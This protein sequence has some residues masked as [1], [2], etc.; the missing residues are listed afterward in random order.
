[1]TDTPNT[2]AR[3]RREDC[4]FGLHFDL[5][6]KKTDTSLG[7]DV[8]E[9]NLAELLDRVRPDFVQ[10]DCKGH[11]GYAGYPTKVGWPSPGVVGDSLAVW[12][13]AT[14]E[15]GVALFIHYSGV[16]DGVALE[17]HPEWAALDAD[18][19]PYPGGQV[20]STFGPYVDELLIPQLI[21]AHQAYD[22]DGAWVDGESWGAELDYSPAALAAWKAKTGRDKAPAGPEDDHWL[23][24]KNFHRE[25][26]DTYLCRWIDGVH[27]ACPDAQLCS[28]W[29]YSIAAPLPKRA[30]VDY[31]SGDY[32]PLLSA[33]TG[34]R[35]ARYLAST[36]MPWDLMS[37][38]FIWN[39]DWGRY[40]K[41]AEPVQQEAGAVL[42]QG[43][44]F[45]IYHH[46]TRS[47]HVCDDVIAVAEEVAAFCRVRQ[48]VSHKSTTVP[49]VALLFS[50]ET[51]WDRCQTPF[52]PEPAKLF[53][54]MQGMLHA[55]LELHY[56]VDILA[57][58]QLAPR[59]SEFPLVVIPDAHV[60]APGFREA[61][62]EYVR[63][64]GAVLLAGAKTA[65]LFEDELGVSF[66]G[67]GAQTPACL[68][69]AAGDV[70]HVNGVWQA[71]DAGDAEV[72]SLRTPT[73]DTRAGGEPAATLTACGE[74]QIGAIY[75][76]VSPAYFHTHHPFLREVIGGLTRRLFPAPAV[77]V[78]GPACVDIA[79]RRTADGRLCLHLLNLA[80]AQ[81][82]ETFIATDH[83]PPVGPLKVALQLDRRP[84]AVHWVP[85]GQA[86]DWDWAD[87]VVS[88]TI[89]QVHI[90]GVVV[91]D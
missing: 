48:D 55:L 4:F 87:G 28:N 68:P 64:G 51:L 88:V 9:K 17:H 79:L 18:G 50:T 71:I 21:E 25:Q 70:A 32:S 77:T 80:A 10:Y 36:G 38:G 5:H 84:A 6:P 42:M 57:E 81:R 86:L 41:P 24:W 27:A 29:M 65:A 53:D 58:H 16:L 39:G 91:V 52:D 40:L 63:N 34:R 15:R 3:L 56:S 23:E 75:G 2:P 12:R 69:A 49:Q 45:Q 11:V 14:A 73:F 76:P 43:G 31:L 82:G 44:G 13:K 37:W 46:P 78:D 30:D 89:P 7:A 19:K 59:L 8:S 83:I 22:L 67:E 26:F 72:V 90:H 20:T 54:E 60:L 33:D 35:Q 85:D 47:G 66:T 61:L 74:G 62:L 1:M